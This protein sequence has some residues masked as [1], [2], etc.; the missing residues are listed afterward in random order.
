MT[1]GEPSR[2]PGGTEHDRTPE[3]PSS[4]LP[5]GVERVRLAL[6]DFLVPLLEE[7][8]EISV[9]ALVYHESGG[10]CLGGLGLSPEE[11]HE[12]M[13]L[14]VQAQAATFRGGGQG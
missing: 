13:K 5:P 8:R 4:A 7:E 9:I 11:G 3:T 10:V 6:H 2:F 12:V 1:A 14:V